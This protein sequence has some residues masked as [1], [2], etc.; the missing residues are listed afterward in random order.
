MSECTCNTNTIDV[1]VELAG[2]ERFHSNLMGR[3]E[4]NQHPISAITN[5]QEKLDE[6]AD[7]ND[8]YSKEEIDAKIEGSLI[9][10]GSVTDYES[11]PIVNNKVGDVYNV[12]STGDNYVWTGNGW[13]KLAGTGTAAS[14]WA[15]KDYVD[16]SVTNVVNVISAHMG[17]HYYNKDEIDEMIQGPSSALNVMVYRGDVASFDKLPTDDI[18]IG[19]LYTIEE[20]KEQYFWDGFGWQ[21]VGI[22]AYTKLEVDEKLSAQYTSLYNEVLTAR[23]AIQQN[24]Q[25]IEAVDTRLTT[26]EEDILLNKNNIES[27][28]NEL[29]TTVKYSLWDN[30]KFIQLDNHDALSGVTTT[31]DGANLIMLSKW[32]V[33]D[34][35]TNKLHM[36]L[37]TVDTITINDDKIVAT[38]EDIANAVSTKADKDSVYTKEEIESR[39]NAIFTYKGNVATE[40]DLPKEATVGDIYNVEATGGNYAWNGTEWDKLSETIDLS[41][42]ITKSQL[43]EADKAILKRFWSNVNN[44]DSGFFFTQHNK[45]NGSYSKLTNEPTGGG[46]FFFNNETG[47]QGF[48]GVNDGTDKNGIYVQLYAAE[49]KNGTYA[50]PRISLTKDKAVYTLDKSSYTENDEIAV[51]GDIK[52][53]KEEIEAE[54]QDVV[55]YSTFET[56]GQERKAIQLANHDV[57]SGI[58]TDGSGHVLAMVSKYDVAD[59]G[60]PKLHTNINT[61][62]IVTVNDTQAILTDAL[63]ERILASGNNVTIEKNQVTDPSTGFK[64]YQYNLSVDLDG[65]ITEEELQKSLETKQ[66][67]GNYVEVAEDGS[68][69]I[70]N[71]IKINADNTIIIK[72]GDTEIVL[73][74]ALSNVASDDTIAKINERLASLE[75]VKADKADFYTKTEIDE[76][77]KYNVKW[78]N[79]TDSEGNERKKIVL[80]NDQVISG[81]GTD[82]NEYVVAMVSRYNV[83]D[84]ANKHLHTNI[85]TQQIVTINDTDAVATDKLLEQL[86]LPGDNVVVEKKS[87]VDPQTS[88]PFNAYEISTDLTGYY[89]KEEVD[90]IHEEIQ[91]SI[92]AVEEAASKQWL[93]MS[94]VINGTNS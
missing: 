31:G 63:L 77:D 29:T 30:R 76:K 17:A 33:V 49:F 91:A 34:I 67:V 57:I 20:T 3:D 40:A 51:K 52:T 15:T 21:L 2:K 58:S 89:T 87:L 68:T 9:Y 4:E 41:D 75:D 8:T 23:E 92:D 79:F 69:Q 16:G 37:N 85:N 73:Q 25:S 78:S 90:G 19:Q 60:S 28:N 35:G 94:D 43:D 54:L 50:G 24:L 32:D 71:A 64:F 36:N 26:A 74:D 59:F 46:S 61:S 84:I 18:Q 62:Q 10:K 13:D 44:P 81:L 11:L 83:T 65:I 7:I 93:S 48:A 66:D 39:L 80:E 56:D 86:I 27:I 70:G 22:D 53:A 14:D 42:Y 12:C 47:Y 55:K 5:L 72:S 82:G 88:F 38:T 6:L 45:E 1:Y